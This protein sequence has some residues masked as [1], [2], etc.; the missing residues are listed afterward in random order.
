[1]ETS[2]RKDDGKG[3]VRARRGGVGGVGGFTVGGVSFYRVEAT[4]G[5]AERL[6]LPA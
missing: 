3:A 5:R 1:M 2:A 4:R 6:K